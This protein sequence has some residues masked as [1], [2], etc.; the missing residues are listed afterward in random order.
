MENHNINWK[1]LDIFEF[2]ELIG[3]EDRAFQFCKDFGLLYNTATCDCGG[4]MNVKRKSSQKFGY[5]FKCSA[6]DYFE[7]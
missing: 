2:I 4:V 3:C 5:Y 7:S 1:R 6:G